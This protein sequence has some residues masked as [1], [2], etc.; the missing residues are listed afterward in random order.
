MEMGLETPIVYVVR[1]TPRHSKN[2]VLV[3]INGL[4]LFFI[5]RIAIIRKLCTSYC[6]SIFGPE[7]SFYDICQ[8]IEN[9]ILAYLYLNY[10]C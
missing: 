3:L 4:M 7:I 1:S 8:H 10:L 6:N 2:T 5:L 9:L